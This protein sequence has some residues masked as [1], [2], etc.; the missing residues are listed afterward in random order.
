MIFMETSDGLELSPKKVEYLKYINERS[1][2]VKTN[3]IASKFKV[4]PSTITKTM[5]ELAE[6]GFVTHIPYHGVTL[7]DSGTNYAG[8]LVKRHRILSL[9]LTHFGLSHEQA[10]EEVSRFESL[11]SKDAIDQICR[12]MGHPH[13]GICGE[14]TH[15]S[16]CLETGI[17]R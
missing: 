5:N 3:E 6:S 17:T 9:M 10:C 4:D 8:F 13:R 16:G 1:G 14:I 11:V 15:D 2:T 12:S 7:S